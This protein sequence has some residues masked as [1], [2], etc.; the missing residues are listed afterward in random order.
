MTASLRVLEGGLR[1]TVQDR[2]RFGWEHVGVARGGALDGFAYA[3]VNRLAGN[4]DGT[5]VLE[6]LLR[7][8]RIAVTDDVWLATAGVEVVTV[9]GRRFPAWSGFAVSAGSEIGVEQ[10]SGARGY[11]SVRGGIV[12]EP[13]LGS[14]S[15]DL[16]SGF[17]GYHGRS[18]QPGDVLP[19]GAPESPAPRDELWR[20]AQPPATGRPLQIRV[21]SGPLQDSWAAG[22]LKWLRSAE[23]S[24]NPQSSHMGIRLDGPLIE[25][26]GSGRE[27]SEPMPIGAV[28]VT[29]AGL[30]LVLLNGRGT[31]GGYPVPATVISAD[32]WL[33]GQARP[34]DRLRFE[35]IT[36]QEA[37]E[38]GVEALHHRETL[39]PVRV[40]LRRGPGR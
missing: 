13:V 35:V 40:A 7:G 18:L 16:E 6:C 38:A 3:W 8:P 20:C 10:L 17:G 36:T 29:T 2:G 27:A 14:R 1:T 11:L 31:V 5:A 33:L 26:T 25:A 39:E 21:T 22:A 23:F 34:G 28:Q 15:T 32:L 12:V 4:P 30:P 37:L 24:V 19:V 9:N